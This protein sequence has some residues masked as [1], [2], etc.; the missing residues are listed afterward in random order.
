MSQVGHGRKAHAEQNTSGLPPIATDARTLRH[1]SRVPR[2]ESL[3]SS[4]SGLQFP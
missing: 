2:A 4:I 3:R 1:F